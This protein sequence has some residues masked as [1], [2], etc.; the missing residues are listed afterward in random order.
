VNSLASG[1][2][3][4]AVNAQTTRFDGD[5]G[6]GPGGNL[7]ALVTDAAGTT[8][9]NAAHVRATTITFLDRLGLIGSTTLDAGNTVTFGGAVNSLFTGPPGSLTVNAGSLVID[10]GSVSTFGDQ[11]YNASVVLGA[12]TAFTALGAANIVFGGTLDSHGTAGG[13]A[14]HRSVTLASTSGSVTFAGDVGSTSRLNDLTVNAITRVGADVKTEGTILLNRAVRVFADGGFDST[15]GD[16]RFTSTIDNEG[17]TAHALSLSVAPQAADSTTIPLIIFQGDIGASGQLGLLTLGGGLGYIPQLSTI[18]FDNGSLTPE[19]ALF[20]IHATG[21]QMGQNQKLV[22]LGSLTMDVGAGAATIGDISAL[23]DLTINAGTLNFLSRAGSVVF[24]PPRTGINEKVSP[25]TFSDTGVDIVARKITLNAGAINQGAFRPSLATAHGIDITG[26]DSVIQRVFDGDITAESLRGTST[27]GTVRYFDLRTDGPT[28]TN[29][30]E[31]IAGAIP[32]E[33]HT[34]QIVTGTSVSAADLDKLKTLGV[35][36]RGNEQAEL[37][38]FLSGRGF[39]VDPHNDPRSGPGKRKRELAADD[40]TVAVGRLPGEIVAMVVKTYES[41]Y[42][43]QDVGYMTGQIGAAWAAYTA[44]EGAQADPRGLLKFAE[45]SPEHAEAAK[46]L[47]DLGDLWMQLGYL[48][49]TPPQLEIAR[50]TSLGPIAPDGVPLKEAV[51]GAA[52]GVPAQQ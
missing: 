10:G 30:S 29:V 26:G 25:T 49:L 28:T 14:A 6:A 46:V 44:A 32:H 19:T 17:A 51:Q 20:T 34:G 45:G 35:Y 15:G 3:A 33:S 37:V 48:G 40:Y 39:Y 18:V 52:E 42:V 36:A 23:G 8:T 38:D 12:D 1:V 31:S 24:G 11:T 4:L 13:G 9:L 21:L 41:I 7:G 16:L 50:A 5:V 22:V 2:S 47:R 27:D 43:Q